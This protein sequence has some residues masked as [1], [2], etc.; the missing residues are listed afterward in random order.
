MR[1]YECVYMVHLFGSRIVRYSQ[2]D[3]TIQYTN[4]QLHL[5]VTMATCVLVETFTH[6]A[7]AVVWCAFISQGFW[8]G[9]GCL[10]HITNP[11]HT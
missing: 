5:G 2:S 6:R 4:M 1:T 7:L 11:D 10:N 8:E 3:Y 9:G